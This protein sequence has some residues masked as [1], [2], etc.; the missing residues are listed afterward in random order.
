RITTRPSRPQKVRANYS[1][2]GSR[3]R[4]PPPVTATADPPLPDHLSAS[5]PEEPPCIPHA[6]LRSFI[7]RSKTPLPTRAP[8][9]TSPPAAPPCSPTEHDRIRGTWHD[10]L[11]ASSLPSPR[12]GGERAGPPGRCAGLLA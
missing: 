2:S 12:L 7:L 6:A 10:G 11:H 8:A 3:F 1:K 5:R 9:F 4:P